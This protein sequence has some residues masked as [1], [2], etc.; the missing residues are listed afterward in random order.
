MAAHHADP[1][2]PGQQLG[3]L[4][5]REQHRA[6]EVRAAAQGLLDVARLGQRVEQRLQ[7]LGPPVGMGVGRQKFERPVQQPLRRGGRA[8]AEHLA[9]GPRVEQPGGRL[10]AGGQP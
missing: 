3:P 1:G 5:R 7:H 8:L 4:L 6:V 9:P 10:V 2:Q